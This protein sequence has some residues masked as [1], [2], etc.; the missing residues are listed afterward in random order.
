VGWGGVGWGK[1][2]ARPPLSSLF[3]AACP[4]C[5]SYRKGGW[6][7]GASGER[8]SLSQP[9]DTKEDRSSPLLS[10]SPR[11]DG[12]AGPGRAGPAGPLLLLLRFC[13]LAPLSGWR[14]TIKIKFCNTLYT[15]VCITITFKHS[16]NNVK[17]IL[18]SL[19]KTTIFFSIIVT[20]S[21]A[22]FKIRYL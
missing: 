21:S 12:R 13:P 11:S 7:G 2:A 6:R 8:R 9:Q 17:L 22:L 5:P 4:V 10:A 16:R 20:V 19:L 15:Q 14:R 1:L 18:S 3:P